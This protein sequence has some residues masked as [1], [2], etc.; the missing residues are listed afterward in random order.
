M[1]PSDPATSREAKKQRTASGNQPKQPEAKVDVVAD[2]K[3][4][5]IRINTIKNSRMLA[6]FRE[7]DSYLTDSE[8]ESSNSEDEDYRPSLAQKDFDNSVLRMG[9][10][11]IAAAKANP[12]HLPSSR[13]SADTV[14]EIIPQVTMRLTRL[15]P[16]GEPNDPRI[17][18]TIQG[19]K[20]M[21]IEAELGE[22]KPAEVPEVIRSSQ[23]SPLQLFFEPTSK[24]NLD[25]SALIALVSDLT[26]ASLPS[27]IDEANKRFIPP[28]KYLEWKKKMT[29]SKAKARA[30]AL[31]KTNAELAADLELD[32]GEGGEGGEGEENGELPYYAK[33]DLAKHSR[34]LTNQVLQEMGKGLLQEMY[35]QLKSISSPLERVEFWTTREARDRC[36]RIV[37]KIGGP[38]EKRRVKALLWDRSLEDPDLDSQELAEEAYWKDSRFGHKFIPLIP[39][40]IHSSSEDEKDCAHS[41]D[42]PAFF[43][44]LDRTCYD[45]LEGEGFNPRN[46]SDRSPLHSVPPPNG[47]NI[48]RAIVTKVNPRLTA[49]TVQS[50]LL[51]ARL[52][53]TTLTANRTSVKA[54]VKEM[55]SRSRAIVF[56][57]GEVLNGEQDDLFN[58]HSGG[59][60][61]DQGQHK[62]GSED[63]DCSIKSKAAI[64]I[65]DPRSLAE[66][67]RSDTET[68]PDIWRTE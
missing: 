41:N 29:A 47:D 3:R 45:I 10:S 25:L 33:Q 67:M 58:L 27:S 37:S 8:T 56:G 32:D 61:D 6:E 18:Q 2:H 42:K 44:S 63:I 68:A 21:G 53:W 13:H 19:L 64:W 59:P 24:I 34:A 60:N 66:G 65:I 62:A 7:I 38:N 54:I 36:L 28:Q 23:P 52:G 16:E 57:D 11:L 40:R 17:A 48:A 39:I 9:R 4:C 49:H 20:D 31:A 46:S 15:D 5:W 51:G 30:V 26:H 43:H 55:N 22:R 1:V 14:T 12:L 35:D 50:M